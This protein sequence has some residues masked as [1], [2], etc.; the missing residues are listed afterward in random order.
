MFR[1]KIST[2]KP[3][4]CSCGWFKLVKDILVVYTKPSLEL[5]GVQ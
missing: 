3:L 1:T 2:K 4:Y 5:M